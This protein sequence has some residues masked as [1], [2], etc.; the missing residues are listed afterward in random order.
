MSE[1][2]T[3]T[4]E[5]TENTPEEVRLENVTYT[6]RANETNLQYAYD[7]K[8]RE[9]AS[10]RF[11][12]R[13]GVTVVSNDCHA[14]GADNDKL[15]TV[16]QRSAAQRPLSSED[17]AN[18]ARLY[19]MQVAQN[20][21]HGELNADSVKVPMMVVPH[22]DDPNALSIAGAYAAADK[23]AVLA[24]RRDRKGTVRIL[25]EGGEGRDSLYQTEVKL[26]NGEVLALVDQK[27]VEG[28]DPDQI[29]AL[30]DPASL[31]TSMTDG[32]VIASYERPQRS[33][34]H[35]AE[36]GFK[37]MQEKKAAEPTSDTVAPVVN[38]S[39]TPTPVAPKRVASAK[40]VAPTPAIAPRAIGETV[41][42]PEDVEPITSEPAEKA[43]PATVEKAADHTTDTPA[44]TAEATTVSPK[45]P[46]QERLAR[47]QAAVDAL[48]FRS[49]A[50]DHIY[51]KAELRDAKI[52]AENEP[53][54][55]EA[56]VSDPVADRLA[57][58]QAAVNA[59]NFKS[60]P[61]ERVFALAELRD[62]KRAHEDALASPVADDQE[63]NEADASRESSVTGDTFHAPDDETRVI[64]EDAAT[65]SID[66]VDRA[67][68][69][70]PKGKLMP[71]KRMLRNPGAALNII[72]ADYVRVRKERRAAEAEY[73]DEAKDMDKRERRRRNIV[74]GAIGV[75]TAI[76]AIRTGIE[77]ANH[78]G[79][80]GVAAPQ[81]FMDYDHLH[82]HHDRIISH[83]IAPPP[84][85]E[86]LT[87]TGGSTEFTQGGLANAHESLQNYEVK[88]GDTIWSL[89]EQYLKTHGVPNPDVFQVDAA[90]DSLLADFQRRGIVGPD[91]WLH[92][93]QTLKF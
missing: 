10:G 71:W 31:E 36:N 88:P 60:T 11:Y 30:L 58:A 13:E 19:R 53:A 85:V 74:L 78:L 46:A 28:M 37:R 42:I 25:N 65:E 80:S 92:A 6:L 9:L 29:A 22:E 20:S 44:D 40:P 93:G 2:I 4:V 21:E 62:A 16:L 39:T 54:S 24:I 84:K 32:K 76:M 14:D 18:A 17:L 12:H 66:T 8:E 91:G 49:T 50:E 5:P 47:A 83:N 90:K 82:P 59:L 79:S 87:G 43:T 48:N 33:A 26:R 77:I 72:L 86:L 75:A 23:D 41:V 45:T 61:E 81:D 34:Q 56:Q 52:A 57:R 64:A 51:A 73:T 63:S 70:E 38:K 35:R 1:R 68:K 55:Q 27:T 67:D 3:P 89:A 15:A 69:P 7:G